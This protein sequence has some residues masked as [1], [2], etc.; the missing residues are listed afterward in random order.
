MVLPFLIHIV[1]AI[2]MFLVVNWLGKQSSSLG[3]IS[4]SMFAREDSAPA[5]NF[6]FRVLSPVVFLIIVST[7]IYAL[8]LDRYVTKIYL[9]VFYNFAFRLLFIT[10]ADRLR[11]IN[12]RSLIPQIVVTILLSLLAYRYLISS[13]D[14]LFP[15]GRTL[16]NELWLAVIVYI[17]AL[18]NRVRAA[19]KDTEDRKLSY[20]RHKYRHLI[21]L[22]GP[23]IREH[24]SNSRLEALIVSVMIVEAFNRPK[25][26]RLVERLLFKFGRAKTLGIMQVKTEKDI[27]DIESAGLG[28]AKIVSDHA[29]VLQG[30]KRDVL[31]EYMRQLGWDNLERYVENQI[32]HEI[33]VRYNYSGDYAREIEGVYSIIIREY[34]NNSGDSI[35]GDLLSGIQRNA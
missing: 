35:M 15:D 19:G 20:I 22:Y 31:P 6:L 7:G 3:Y 25:C 24:T 27:T 26:Y 30:Y 1:L 10:A 29:S 33:L 4:L 18:F 12:W 16:G 34:Y 28:A 8:G 21:T 9:V 2:A 11:L 32:I 13:K 14:V 17:Y 23:T 5:F